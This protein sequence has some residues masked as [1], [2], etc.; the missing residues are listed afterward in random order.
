MAR[1]LAACSRHCLWLRDAEWRFREPREVPVAFFQFRK[2]LEMNSLLRRLLQ[3]RKHGAQN[4]SSSDCEYRTHGNWSI[5]YGWNRRFCW[6]SGYSFSLGGAAERTW[7]FCWSDR[8][9]GSAT[10]PK[11]LW[12]RPML[13]LVATEVIVSWELEDRGC[14]LWSLI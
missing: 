5:Q 4:I 14:K 3:K 10:V 11:S 6:F 8:D 9:S 7:Y 13:A 12:S 2:G 1:K